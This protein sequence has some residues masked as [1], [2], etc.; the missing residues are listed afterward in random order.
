[1]IIQT[2]APPDLATNK[3]RSA[4][5]ILVKV[6]LV[7]S[8]AV[9]AVAGALAPD[10]MKTSTLLAAAIGILPVLPRA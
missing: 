3:A 6:T 7:V 1:M 5:E 4:V 10:C 2:T 9:I 8:A